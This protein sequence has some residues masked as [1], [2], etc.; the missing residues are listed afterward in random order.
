MTCVF[1]VLLWVLG[2]VTSSLMHGPPARLGRTVAAGAH[3]LEHGQAWTPLTAAAFAADLPGYLLGTVV[4]LALAVPA[5]RRLGGRRFAVAAL[6]TQVAGVLLALG[7]VHLIWFADPAWAHELSRHPAV[8]PTTVAVGVALVASAAM[9]TLWRRR[10]R[11]G[12]LVVL[13]TIMLYGGLLEDLVRFCC[14]LV[15]LLGGPLLTGARHRAHRGQHGHRL[16]GTR[17]EGRVLVAIVVAASAL[18]PIL[19]AFFPTA[20][21]PLSVLRFLFTSAPPDADIVRAICLDPTTAMEPAAPAESAQALRGGALP[22]V[23]AARTAAGG[24]V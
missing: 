13:G 2:A 19:A 8:G 12:L 5:E 11:V 23:A 3:G 18:G 16:T 4:V 7:A 21:G 17:R 6:G 24:A 22:L 9:T 1:L 20:V 15:G 14:A 10:L